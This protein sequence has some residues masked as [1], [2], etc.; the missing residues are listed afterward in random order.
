MDN[1][2]DNLAK[3]ISLPFMANAFLQAKILPS[4]LAFD[5]DAIEKMLTEM[6]ACRATGVL[7]YEREGD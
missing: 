6:D 5:Y 7:R 4:T 3:C 1:L 2:N